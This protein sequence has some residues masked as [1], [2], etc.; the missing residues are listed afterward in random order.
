MVGMIMKTSKNLTVIS[1]K[2]YNTHDTSLIN[3]CSH[4][5]AQRHTSAY[6]D[7]DEIRCRLR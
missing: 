7:D 5:Y 3:V 4:V 6:L 2:R 1:R